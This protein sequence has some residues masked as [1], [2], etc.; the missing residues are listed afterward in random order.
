M[1]YYNL[2]GLIKARRSATT[3]LISIFVRR[4]AAKLNGKQNSAASSRTT[5]APP[6]S[7]AIANIKTHPA[8]QNER[9]FPCALFCGFICFPEFHR[10]FLSAF[11]LH[12]QNFQPNH[13]HF[14]SSFTHLRDATHFRTHHLCSPGRDNRPFGKYRNPTYPLRYRS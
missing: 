9:L 1:A 11:L 5:T 6:R 2:R 10:L 14:A 4:T 3:F 12:F 13:A 8:V 7:S